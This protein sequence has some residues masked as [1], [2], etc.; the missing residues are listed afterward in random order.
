M[1][2]I[3]FWNARASHEKTSISAIATTRCPR[4]RCA[5]SGA[6]GSDIQA[7]LNA[8]AGGLAPLAASLLGGAIYAALGPAL[9]H[10]TGA[11]ADPA[12]RR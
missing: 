10:D 7:A 11:I 1:A 6:N 3:S 8:G 12:S 4:K 2:L 5:Y 9:L